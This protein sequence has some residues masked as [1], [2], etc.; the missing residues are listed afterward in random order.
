MQ[1]GLHEMSKTGHQLLLCYLKLFQ[2]LMLCASS[3]SETWQCI[4]LDTAECLFYKTM[5][6]KRIL[7]ATAITIGISHIATAQTSTGNGSTNGPS[8]SSSRAKAKTAKTK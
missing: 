4:C 2:K 7:L 8:V 5:V 3:D 1:K 6:M